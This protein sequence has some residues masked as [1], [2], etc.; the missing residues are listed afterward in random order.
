[1]YVTELQEEQH[2]HLPDPNE[3]EVGSV[4]RLTPGGTVRTR[5]YYMFVSIFRDGWFYGL[6]NLGTGNSTRN[7]WHKSREDLLRDLNESSTLVTREMVRV[8]QVIL[9]D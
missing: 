6:L 5:E 9:E 7:G 4:W 1:M 2:Y 3:L 8:N